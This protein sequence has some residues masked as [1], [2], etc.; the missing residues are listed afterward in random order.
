M[1]VTEEGAG[2]EL[3]DR[4]KTKQYLNGQIE[5]VMEA[6]VTPAVKDR[7]EAL[8]MEL[9]TFPPLMETIRELVT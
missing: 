6:G 9:P 2:H 8:A 7:L 5:S 1:Q 3:S 4:E